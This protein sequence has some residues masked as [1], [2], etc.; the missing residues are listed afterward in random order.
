M[1]HPFSRTENRAA[2]HTVHLQR[3]GRRA[4]RARLASGRR[5]GWVVWVGAGR[6]LWGVA[7]GRAWRVRGL[8]AAHLF[9]LH[10]CLPP[11]SRSHVHLCADQGGH[12]VHRGS[13]QH[14]GRRQAHAPRGARPLPSLAI[15]PSR[16]REL[17]LARGE[18]VS[19]PL[20]TEGV[21][22]CFFA[23]S[24]PSCGNAATRTSSSAG[25]CS[26]SLCVCVLVCCTAS[27]RIREESTS[28][29]RAGDPH[30][31]TL[32]PPNPKNFSNLWIVL[33]MCKWDLGKVRCC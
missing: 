7:A 31:M 28:G 23:R 20:F 14:H 22:V 2:L 32:R 17:A 27:F 16:R 18:L 9:T 5:G 15:P 25:M 33:N 30:R 19:S 3:G 11:L 1:R 4:K 8:A 29:S 10:L 13:V 24:C 21:H 12:Q 26:F 6:A